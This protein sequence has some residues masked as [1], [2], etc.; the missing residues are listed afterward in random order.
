MCECFSQVKGEF[1]L[2][3]DNTSP[4]LR[5]TSKVICDA[6]NFT[7]G[8]VLGH[9]RDNKPCVIYYIRQTLDEA[10]VNYAT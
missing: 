9:K 10:Q 6:N 3:F 1:D 4:T 2:G 8:V 5:A 7:L